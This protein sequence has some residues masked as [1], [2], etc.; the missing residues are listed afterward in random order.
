MIIS[1]LVRLLVRAFLAAMLV[2]AVAPALAAA[3]YPDRPIRMIVPFSAGGPT[4]ALARVISEYLTK[5]LGVS[6]VVDNRGGAGGRIATEVAA[7]AASDG[8]TVFFATT[9][10]MAINPALYRTMTLKPA[11]AFDAIGPIASSWNVLEVMPDFPANTLQDLIRLAK[12][13]PGALTFGSAG[14]GS[15]NHLSGEL[16]KRTA[17]IDIRHVPY[18]GSSGAFSDLIGGRISMMFD[19]LPTGVPN[20]Q[21]GRVKA[22]IQTGPRRSAALPDVPTAIEAGLPAFDVTTFFGLVAPKGTPANVLQ[23]LHDALVKIL[24]Q[25]EVKKKLAGLGA[26][27]IAGSAQDLQKLIRDDTAKWDKLIREA[28]IHMD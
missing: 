9:G 26:V 13:K 25:D 17:D 28:D 11:E 22:L 23:R 10:T 18:K 14:I 15:T 1:R 20:V 5:N 6:V 21:S 7:M 2:A 8:Y 4:D 16:L 12:K 24:G 19:T 27:P 3:A